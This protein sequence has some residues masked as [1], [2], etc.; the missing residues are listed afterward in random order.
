MRPEEK[1]ILKSFIPGL[2]LVAIMWAVEGIEFYTHKNFMHY[3]VF[4]RSI[5]A[6]TGILTTPFIHDDLKHLFSNSVPLVIL[7]AALI[8]FYRD[9]SF[10]VIVL[11]WLLTG[12]WL[13]LGGRPAWHIGA[14]GIVYGLASFL[15]F[16]GVFRKHRNLMALSLLITFL[17]GGLVWGVF[18]L[19]EGMSWESHLFG[20]LAGLFVAFVYRKEGPQRKVYDWENEE[21]DEEDEGMQADEQEESRIVR[22]I[23]PSVNYE[24]KENPSTDNNDPNKSV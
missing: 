13:W 15:F 18:P 14:S 5:E 9:I 3:G 21:D 7:I 10:K 4:P 19:M 11:V 1:S 16:S 22:S 23:P 24:Y 2:L 6:M 8:Y 20:G 17:Y 12:A